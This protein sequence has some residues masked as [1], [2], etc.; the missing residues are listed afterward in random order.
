M[1]SICGLPL[2]V[3]LWQLRRAVAWNSFATVHQVYTFQEFYT[4]AQYGPDFGYYSTGRILHADGPTDNGMEDQEESQA[5][6][7]SYTTLPMSLSPDFA[8]ALCDRLVTMWQAMGRPSPFV[9]TEFGG[10]TGMLARD[11][12]RRARDAHEAFYV[13]LGRYFIGERSVALRSAQ[14]RTAAEFVSA[15]KLQIL[16]ADGR[17]AS[18]V[19]EAMQEVV[20]D[21]QLVFGIVLSNELLDEFDPVRLRLVWHKGHPPTKGQCKECKAFREAHVLHSVDASALAAL[22]RSASA[23]PASALSA[24]AAGEEESESAARIAAEVE[25]IAWEGNSMFCG[26]LNTPALVHAIMDVVEE[27]L[28]SERQWCAPSMVCCLPFILAVDQALQ[29]HHEALQRQTVSRKRADGTPD[30]LRLYRFHLQRTNGTVPLTKLRYAEL[31]R[32]AAARGSEVEKALLAGNPA[33]LPG[34]VHSTEVFFGLSPERCRELVGW[35]RRNAARLTSAAWLRDGSTSIFDG[36]LTPPRTAVHLKLVLR[37]GEAAFAETASHL[38]D[39]GFLVTMDYGADADALAWQALIRPN[40]EG[41]HIVDARNENYDQ[42]TAVS[43]LECPGLQDLTTSVDFT[44]VAVAGKELG[45]WN[46]K[47]YGPIFLLELGFDETSLELGLAGDLL[48]LGHLVERA[49]GLRSLGLQAWY[50][51]LEL[52]PWASFKLLVQHRGSR[53]SE[54]NL[55]HLSMQ[56]P[57]QE[58]PRLFRAPSPCWGRDLT[59]PPLASLITIAAH[60]TLGNRAW[61]VYVQDAAEAKSPTEAAALVL[62]DRG[63]APE[64][65]RGVHEVLL[66]QFQALLINGGQPLAHLLDQQHTSQQQAYA[67]AHLA[68]ILVDYWRFL[69]QEEVRHVASLRHFPQ[70]YGERTFDRVFDDLSRFVFANSTLWGRDEFPPYVCLAAQALHGTCCSSPAKASAA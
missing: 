46:V 26:L 34:R 13:A 29:Y 15:G 41:I 65:E 4:D 43:Y 8:H 68:L 11:I 50:R 39:E 21:G 22:L 38:V 1:R 23:S 9:L 37:P 53:G 42:C 52:D 16:Q 70:L 44:E 3:A 49:N 69:G 20:G 6:F 63:S 59:K 47:A 62:E 56:W 17:H 48:N 7:N 40:Y 58:M 57:L 60:H 24:A 18:Q 30:L 31:R 66:R 28:P 19:R 54:W 25:E 64:E 14:N 12:L 32:R 35:M 33:L 67:D 61:A 36:D 27:L 2:A 51:K 5:W 55:G 10:G 45:G